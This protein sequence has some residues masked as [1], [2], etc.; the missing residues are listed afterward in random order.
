MK[1]TRYTQRQMLPI[2]REVN[3]ADD[4]MALHR[5]FAPSLRA[6]FRSTSEDGLQGLRM[7]L[8]GHEKRRT[9]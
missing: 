5:H 6:L 3:A 1:K 2:I 4:C 7:A 8:P 9:L